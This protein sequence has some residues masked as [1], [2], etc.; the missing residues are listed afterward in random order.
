MIRPA[1]VTLYLP[2]RRDHTLGADGCTTQGGPS[3][4]PFDSLEI[5]SVHLQQCNK[6]G[7]Q[8][9]H[10][11]GSQEHNRSC[12]RGRNYIGDD[13][14]H[15]FNLIR[16]LCPWNLWLLVLKRKRVTTDQAASVSEDVASMPLLW[17]PPIPVLYTFTTAEERGTEARQSSW[18]L[19]ILKNGLKRR[20]SSFR[21]IPH[22]HACLLWSKHKVVALLACS[23]F[24]I[25]LCFFF[26]SAGFWKWTRGSLENGAQIQ[27]KWWVETYAVP[28]HLQISVF[29]IS[30]IVKHYNYSLKRA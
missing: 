14:A 7:E 17:N 26:F 27:R 5:Y 22:E 12:W 15:N 6:E 18:N 3:M 21:N 20:H 28:R 9:W 25:L 16:N 4:A 8:R 30:C 19:S 1:V 13:W 29:G 10:T 24:F 2:S 23:L 11:T